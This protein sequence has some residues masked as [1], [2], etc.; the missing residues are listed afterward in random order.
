MKKKVFAIMLV[1][2]MALA[3]V[4]CGQTQAQP[5]ATTTS[6]PQV[7]EQKEEPESQ[8]VVEEVKEEPVQE[9]P[10]KEE[11]EKAEEV[12]ADNP[13]VID[14]VDCTA[15]NQGMNI[16][17]FVD[18][19]DCDTMRVFVRTDNGIEAV[20]SDGD[21]IEMKEENGQYLFIYYSPKPVTSV[22]RIGDEG[23]FPDFM[24]VYRAYMGHTIV[25]DHTEYE[26]GE[27]ITVGA[28]V[29][30]EDGTEDSITIHLTKNY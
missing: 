4:A 21:S 9:E 30:Y 28:K 15:F 24:I 27:D 12:A 18:T 13:N 5:E 16:L 17:D 11:S 20:L 19:V 2:T 7:E 25:N 6:E 10:V 29:V 1:V 14:G 8:P 26:A 22:E 3:M 23:Y